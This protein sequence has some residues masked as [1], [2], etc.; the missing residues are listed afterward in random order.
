[1]AVATPLWNPG[2]RTINDTDQDTWNAIQKDFDKLRTQQLQV[3]DRG[4]T[5]NKYYYAEDL[6]ALFQWR[7]ECLWYDWGEFMGLVD[8]GEPREY[9]KGLG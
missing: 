3:F 4:S 5:Q 7:S 1:M 2:V 6:I 9:K 8:G